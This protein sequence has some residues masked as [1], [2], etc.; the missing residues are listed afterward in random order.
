MRQANAGREKGRINTRV[1]NTLKLTLDGAKHR[2]GFRK[3]FYTDALNYSIISKEV[4]PPT[5]KHLMKPHQLATKVHFPYSDEILTSR[6][7]KSG[8]KSLFVGEASYERKLDDHYLGSQPPDVRGH[9]IQV[10]KAF[11]DLPSL[12]PFLIRD[13]FATEGLKIDEAYL[14][15]PLEE[16]NRIKE[17]IISRFRPLARIAFGDSVP[18]IEEK[19]MRLVEK[20]WEALDHQTLEPLTR[21]LRI[22]TDDAPALYYGWKG[23][24]YYAFKWETMAADLRSLIALVEALEAQE[25]SRSRSRLEQMDWSTSLRR[26][27]AIRD[28][29]KL[30]LDKYHA[31]YDNFFVHGREPGEFSRFFSIAEDLFWLLGGGISILDSCIEQYVK[32]SSMPARTLEIIVAFNQDLAELTQGADEE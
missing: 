4:V 9:D 22:N 10:L 3:L 18:N 5:M 25:K 23:V 7:Y 6:N 30:V 1:F 2:P 14:Q 31:V 24:V 17:G 19:T 32:F 28:E 13:K 8:G 15:V 20:M 29:V 27:R 21:A 11:N 12:D 26:I 16:W